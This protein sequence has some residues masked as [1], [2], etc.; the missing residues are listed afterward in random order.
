MKW[1]TSWAGRVE[2]P[3]RERQSLRGRLANV[4][5]WVARSS[6]GHERFRRVD[7]RHGLRSEPRDQLGGEGT[8]AAADVEHP[9]AATHPGEVGQLGG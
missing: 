7:G 4:D 8:G 3:L 1:T 2:R 5:A 6:S 9:L